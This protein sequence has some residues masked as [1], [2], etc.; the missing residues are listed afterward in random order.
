M[1]Y[2]GAMKI[3]EWRRRVRGPFRIDQ[4][5]NRSCYELTNGHPVRSTPS[6]P[7]RAAC[8]LRV[9]RILRADPGFG[10]VGTRVGYAPNALTLRCPDVVAEPDGKSLSP[11]AQR[12][13]L[14][15]STA[16]MLSSDP[17]ADWVSLGSPPS[18]E[19]SP[20]EAL[21]GDVS[22]P[23]WLDT[24]PSLAIEIVE[25]GGDVDDLVQKIDEL[26]EAGTQHVWALRLTGPRRVEVYSGSGSQKTVSSGRE[27]RAEGVLRFRVPVVAF[28]EDEV[29]VEHILQVHRYENWSVAES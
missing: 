21:G 27:L 25:A 17:G 8:I 10:W 28:F 18:S 3:C 12:H 22:T 24:A 26:L 4:V 9:A 5:P 23:S 11:M 19:P 13:T 20:V 14:K 15:L 2:A 29:A 6:T 16:L 7:E 1:E